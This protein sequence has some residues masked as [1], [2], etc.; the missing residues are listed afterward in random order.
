VLAQDVELV[1][2]FRTGEQV[3]CVGVLCDQLQRPLLTATTDH[4]VRARPLQILR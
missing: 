2:G 3:A 1:R 4:Q